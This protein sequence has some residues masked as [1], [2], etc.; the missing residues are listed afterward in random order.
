LSGK[1]LPGGRTQI[2][3]VH[4]ILQISRHPVDCDK[5]CAAQSIPDTQ[6]WLNWNGDLDDPNDCEDDCTAVG[7]CDMEQDNAI[8][9]PEC[10]EQR[11]VSAVPHVAGLIHHTWK[12]KRQ[13]EKVLVTVN[14]TETRRN[15][16]VKTK[17]Y[18]IR[19]CFTSCY[20]YL[21]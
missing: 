20:M 18:I 8:E 16:R 17:Y 10:P 11:D 19:Q 21:G 6:D 13:A 1:N 5:D 7:E 12:S 2:L 15:T 4:Q 14:A 3:N 9:D